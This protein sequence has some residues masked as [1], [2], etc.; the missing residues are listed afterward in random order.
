MTTSLGVV[1]DSAIAQP[2]PIAIPTLTVLPPSSDTES[3]SRSPSP[4][5]RRPRSRRSRAKP[6]HRG[7]DSPEDSPQRLP[8]THQQ[9]EGSWGTGE[10]EDAGGEETM[11]GERKQSSTQRRSP[12]P[13]PSRSGEEEDDVEYE[14]YR[15]HQRQGSPSPLLLPPPSRSWSRS[16]SPSRRS[17]WSLRSLLSRDASSDWDSCRSVCVCFFVCALSLV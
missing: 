1:P 9:D 10:G 4:R 2:I 14:E 17:R 7:P 6:R 8:R 3:W 11:Q 5:C 12:S 15:R 16:R 13:S